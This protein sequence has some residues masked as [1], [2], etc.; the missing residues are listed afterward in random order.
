MDAVRVV[1]GLGYVG[2]LAAVGAGIAVNVGA[3]GIPASLSD[4]TL[5]DP[6]LRT[7]RALPPVGLVATFCLCIWGFWRLAAP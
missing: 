3:V 1:V 2:L 7:V 4:V 5:L 6:V